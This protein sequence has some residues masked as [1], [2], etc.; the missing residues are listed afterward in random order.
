MTSSSIKAMV[1]NRP[2]HLGNVNGSFRISFEYGTNSALPTLTD[3]CHL[4]GQ[5]IKI[6]DLGN[7]L[8]FKGRLQTE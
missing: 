3:I 6:V 7:S 2:W 1:L 8:E 5:L 4:R